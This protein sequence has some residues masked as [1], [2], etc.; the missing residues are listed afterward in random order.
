[1]A[2]HRKSWS[3]C[4]TWEE[5]LLDNPEWASYASET[6]LDWTERVEEELSWDHGLESWVAVRL[7]RWR[8][9][10]SELLNQRPE[11]WEAKRLRTQRF[12]APSASVCMLK[13]LTS[14]GS[15]PMQPR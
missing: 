11:A 10:G 13:G 7:D 15:W 1:M 9:R 14:V 12:A 2:P 4:T 3:R 8:F 5:I 6:A